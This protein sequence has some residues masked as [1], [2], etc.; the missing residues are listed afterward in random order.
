VRP[1]RPTRILGLLALCGLLSCAPRPAAVELDTSRTSPPELL[2]RVKAEGERVRTLSGSGSLSFESPEVSGSA[3]FRVALRKPD[4]LLLR[5]RGYFGIDLG[6]LF[7]ERDRFLIYN[8]LENSLIEGSPASSSV[9]A[10]LPTDLT[11]RELLD[12]FTGRYPLDLSRGRVVRYDVEE[13]QF[14]LS[15]EEGNEVCDL[16]VDPVSLLVTQYRR[17]DRGGRVLVDIEADAL[18]DD[19]GVYVPRR[20]NLAFPASG[21]QISLSYSAI[22]INDPE[23]SFSFTLPPGV[24]RTEEPRP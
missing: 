10:L 14:V 6:F 7:L 21:R 4:S 18:T 22:S 24:Q 5:L 15:V 20:I 3:F 23:P 9:R 1:I 12:A 2:E 19:D 17:T 16:R 8:S 11:P 13:G